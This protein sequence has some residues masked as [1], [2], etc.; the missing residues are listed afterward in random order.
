MD[1]LNILIARV[2]R[3]LRLDPSLYLEVEGDAGATA[4][5]IVILLVTGA[6]TGMGLA[7]T[8]ADNK[9]G[10]VSIF[11]MGIAASTV[12]WLC[13][14]FITYILGSTLFASKR[15]E[16]SFLV[17][18][19]SVSFSASPGVLRFFIFIPGVGL[20]LD[21]VAQLWCIAGMIVALR[22]S[23]DFQ[24]GRAAGLC[25]AGW[26]IYSVLI[27]GLLKSLGVEIVLPV[28]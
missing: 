5:A 22:R 13:L 18:F 20:L 9:I 24:T 2:V 15:K 3:A 19:R 12:G 6:C 17:L 28:K 21:F 11:F 26:V 4:Q 23:F 27:F 10:G 1:F 14:L 16:L 8:G 25:V 7:M